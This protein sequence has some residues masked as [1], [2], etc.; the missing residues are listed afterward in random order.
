MLQNQIREHVIAI[1]GEGRAAAGLLESAGE[2]APPARRGA[3][4]R[5]C[6][7]VYTHAP[8]R[9]TRL[10]RGGSFAVLLVLQGRETAEEEAEGAASSAVEDGPAALI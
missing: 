2:R 4:A 6:A 1:E 3:R 10:P 7:C 5:V 9:G 8:G